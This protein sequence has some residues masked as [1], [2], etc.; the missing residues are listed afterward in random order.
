MSAK[1]WCFTQNNPI[2]TS[3]ELDEL[4]RPLAGYY[5]F[6]LEEGE[7]GTPHYQGYVQFHNR[8]RLTGVRKVLQAHWSI[9]KGSPDENTAYCTKEPR[10]K[11]SVQHGIA[12]IQGQRQDVEQFRDKILEGKTNLELNEEFPAMC[13]KFTK[14]IEWTRATKYLPRSDAPNVICLYGPSGTG[15]TR[16]A[17]EHSGRENTYMVDK[18]D[19]GR[20]LW[21]DGYNPRDHTTVVIDD[22]YGWLPWSYILRLLD[23]YAFQVEVKGGKVHFNS[24]TIYITS[25]QHPSKWYKN[26]PNDDLTPLLR[27]ITEIKLLDKF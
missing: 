15:K 13:M 8:K 2:L 23:R 11:N 27:R 17:V 10:L 7:S 12:S 21:W 5:V 3:K 18:P 1:N 19:N 14:Y 20:P 24:P 25:N 6:Q 4:L 26:I 16:T 9:A 22:F